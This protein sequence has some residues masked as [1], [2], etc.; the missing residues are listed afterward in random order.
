VTSADAGSWVVQSVALRPRQASL[1]GTGAAG[2]AVNGDTATLSLPR[3]SGV[4]AG[5]V[6]IAHVVLHTH[7]FN[8]DPLGPPAGWN[9]VRVDTD[10]NH[11]TAGVFWRLATGSEPADYTFTNNSGDT[12]QQATGVVLA[13]RGLDTIDP[14]DDD[15]V[16][17]DITGSDTVVAPSLTTSHPGGRLLS[18]V[19]VYGNDQG[20]ADPPGSMTERY[21]ST[22]VSETAVIEV[23]GEAADEVLPSAG[24]T[25][26]RTTSVPGT[27]TSVVQAIALRPYT[28]EPYVD[29]SWTP[30]TSPSV[31]G[32]I[33]ERRIGGTLDATFTVTPGTASSYTDGPLT[34]GTTYTYRVIATAGTWR[35]T[36]LTTTYTPGAC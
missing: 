11:V 28:G 6:L 21:E 26:T 16:A 14:I 22:V 13:Y 2:V 7:S 24:A 31:D 33:V 4:A 29:L 3:P 17:T 34:P 19:G 9:E 20:P 25:G 18:L 32:Y 12:T 8:A 30:S 35:S 27:D 23:L 1:V 15:A 5:D 10:A 36:P